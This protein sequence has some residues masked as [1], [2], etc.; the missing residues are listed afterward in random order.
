M[1]NIESTAS[2]YNTLNKPEV[3]NQNQAK[4]ENDTMSSQSSVIHH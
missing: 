1:E 3:Q 2:E 4:F